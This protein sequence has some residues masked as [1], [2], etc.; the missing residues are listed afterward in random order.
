MSDN[1]RVWELMKKIGICMF[2]SWNGQELQARPMGA[3]VRPDEH[4]VSVGALGGRN[5][6]LHHV[7]VLC[8]FAVG[9]PE[10]VPY[11]A[12][13]RTRKRRDRLRGHPGQGQ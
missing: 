12:A 6:L 1:D 4:A 7:P 8:D 11:C 10:D 2:A 13:E 3:Y 5:L 9:D